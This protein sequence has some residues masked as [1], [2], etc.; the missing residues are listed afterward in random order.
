[1]RSGQR[2]REVEGRG[3]QKENGCWNR[4]EREDK[5]GG[6]GHKR[7]QEGEEGEEEEDRRVKSL[8]EERGVDRKEKEC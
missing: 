3:M 1:M 2:W 8:K 7:K 4:G 6:G 5:G